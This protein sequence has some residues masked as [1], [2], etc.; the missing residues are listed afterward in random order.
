[1]KYINILDY[2]IVL[3]LVSLSANTWSQHVK[4][5]TLKIAIYYT[6]NSKSSFDNYIATQEKNVKS[7]LANINKDI[8]TKFDIKF[9]GKTQLSYIEPKHRSNDYS[10]KIFA[11]GYNQVLTEL[12]YHPIFDYY[13]KKTASTSHPDFKLDKNELDYNFLNLDPMVQSDI[14]IILVDDVGSYDITLRTNVL[15]NDKNQLIKSKLDN[16]LYAVISTYRFKNDPQAL[17]IAIYSILADPSEAEAT[18]GTLLTVW[19]ENEF[20]QIGVNNKLSPNNAKLFQCNVS[21]MI[22][23][24]KDEKTINSSIKNIETK[25][26][27]DADDRVLMLPKSGTESTVLYPKNDKNS[28]M[29]FTTDLY[30][31]ASPK[32]CPYVAT[33]APNNAGKSAGNEN[34]GVHQD[35]DL[36]TDIEITSNEEIETLTETLIVYPNPTS[37]DVTFDV[38]VSKS[39]GYRLA[40]YNVYGQQAMILMDENLTKGAH[41]IRANVAGLVTGIYIYRL[42]SDTSE[43]ISGRIIVK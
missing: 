10:N 1:M 16:P 6:A 42:E 5:P 32:S 2:W 8:I 4:K 13:Y 11:D 7:V 38:N 41:Q 22:L 24:S 39:G 29:V 31:V 30:N 17:A 26:I 40:L 21:E 3:V 28:Y 14:N 27:I 20:S 36:D 37:G 12:V 34:F 43:P 19:Q 18:S 15:Y 25:S 23:E 33:K 9:I 35:D